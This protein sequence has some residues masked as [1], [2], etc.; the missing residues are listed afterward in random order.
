MMKAIIY[1]FVIFVLVCTSVASSKEEVSFSSQR[2]SNW[3]I[4]VVYFP[5]L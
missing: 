3:S 4:G 1:I 5:R 2:K